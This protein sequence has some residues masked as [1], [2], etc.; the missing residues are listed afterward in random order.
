MGLATSAARDSRRIGLSDRGST[1]AIRANHQSAVDS[2]DEVNTFSLHPSIYRANGDRRL[3]RGLL[4][5]YHSKSSAADLAEDLRSGW[6]GHNDLP[7]DLGNYLYSPFRHGPSDSSAQS[8]T[9]PTRR[10]RASTR[11]PVRRQ[12]HRR[13]CRS[14]KLCLVVSVSASTGR[15]LLP[16][17]PML[18]TAQ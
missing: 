17:H 4:R 15:R 5:G 14:L 6:S 16:P 7:L 8:S 1:Q 11:I 12:D 9:V 10:V 18:T 13:A 2:F 3:I